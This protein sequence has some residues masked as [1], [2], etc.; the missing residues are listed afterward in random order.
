MSYELKKPR[1]LGDY[2]SKML[3]G[4]YDSSAADFLPTASMCGLPHSMTAVWASF[5]DEEGTSYLICREM[6]GYLTSTC[7]VMT[8]KERK[9]LLLMPESRGLWNGGLIIEQDGTR[10]EWKSTDSYQGGEPRYHLLYDDGVIEYREGDLVNVKGCCEASGYQFYEPTHQQGQTTHV[11]TVS[12]TVAG[13]AVIGLVGINVHFQR[14][15]INYRI[16]PM[17]LGGQMLTWIDVGNIYE[18]GSWEKGPIVVGRDGYSGVW[19]SNDKG[20]VTYSCDVDADFAVDPDGFLAEMNFRYRDARTG[21]PYH[22]VWRAKPGANM[23]ELPALA[24]HLKAKR[25]AEGYCVRHG[26]NRKLRYSSS[27]P[28]FQADGR[29]E[30]FTAEMAANTPAGY[31]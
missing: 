23:V 11:A 10:A 9:G 30:K 25:S 1:G 2:G 14:P 28:E 20:E 26:E 12:G 15:G 29:V 22:W 16:S 5:E 4:N 7:W 18:D 3:F 31:S 17:V 6:S 19:I 8:N 21:A 13:K 27:W 24:P